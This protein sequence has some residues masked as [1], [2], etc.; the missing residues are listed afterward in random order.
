MSN[1]SITIPPETARHVLW[2]FGEERGY[3]PGNFTQGLLELLARADIVNA[4]RLS[5]AY[6]AEAEAV[7]LAKYDENGLTQLHAIAA[8]PHC[9]DCGDTDGP[10]AERVEGYV[11]EPC[12]KKRAL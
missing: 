7:R 12:T 6:P 11:C 10:F 3:R 1:D 8:Q 5:I 2:V 4:A 9:A